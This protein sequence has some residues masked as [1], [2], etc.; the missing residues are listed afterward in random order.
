MRQQQLRVTSAERITEARQSVALDRRPIDALRANQSDQSDD[1]HHHGY[2]DSQ[3][4]DAGWLRWVL[5]VRSTA[6]DPGNKT[7]YTA[8][9]RGAIPIRKM[10]DFLTHRHRPVALGNSSTDSLT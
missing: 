6:D 9:R 7:S 10:T 8:A 1:Q 2:D 4:Q 3:A 5:R